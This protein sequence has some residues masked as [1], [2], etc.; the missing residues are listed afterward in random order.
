MSETMKYALT[1]AGFDGSAGA[2]ILADVKA[3]AHFGV[4]CEAVCTALTVQNE[5]EFVSPGWVIWDRIEA[6]LETVFKKRTFKY[7]K[8]GLVEKAKVLKRIVEF[9]REKSPDAYIIWDPIA[10]ASAGFHFLRSTER[11]EFIPVMKQIDLVTPNLDEYGFLG[12]E[13]AAASGKFEFGKDF[14]VLLKGGHSTDSDAI[15]TLW[16]KDG[17]QYKFTCPR[18][19]GQGKHGTGCNLSSAILAN[20]ALGRTLPE[21]CKIAKDYLNE[22][23]QSGEG[24]LG[25]V[26]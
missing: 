20:I 11:N 25:F 13:Q 8:I 24:R 2:G 5:D 21:S 16:D 26:K 10:S 17:K 23:L 3:M 7:V 14:A 6:Q 4:Y 12:L 9:V 15:D 22:L 19:P 1:I 18:L